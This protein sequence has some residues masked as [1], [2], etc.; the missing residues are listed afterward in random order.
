MSHCSILET[1]LRNDN[2]VNPECGNKRRV[3]FS[4]SKK[5]MKAK[6][7]VEMGHNRNKT[8]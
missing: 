3:Q 6:I 1:K 8:S 5:D 2:L 4:L 7:K